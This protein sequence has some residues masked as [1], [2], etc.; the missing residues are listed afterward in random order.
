[1]SFF[2]WAGCLLASGVWLY[3][4]GWLVL[5]WVGLD[6]YGLSESKHPIL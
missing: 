6:A 4:R 5:D 1:M 2:F 3:S